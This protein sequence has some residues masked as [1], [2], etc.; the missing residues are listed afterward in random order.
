[1]PVCFVD[2]RPGP[3]EDLGDGVFDAPAYRTA[4]RRDLVFVM[5][6]ACPPALPRDHWRVRGACL[7]RE[8]RSGKPFC[9]RRE[10]S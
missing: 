9:R 10:I 8:G 5:Q 2:A 6:L 4:D 7:V 3:A 1:M